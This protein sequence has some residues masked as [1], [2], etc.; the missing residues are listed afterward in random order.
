MVRGRRPSITAAASVS[1]AQ[2]ISYTVGI[3]AVGDAWTRGEYDQQWS[4]SADGAWGGDARPESLTV[5]AEASARL[6]TPVSLGLRFYAAAGPVI[7][8]SPYVEAAV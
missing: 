8:L 3:E 5:E 1:A 7:E 4:T 2:T 6:A